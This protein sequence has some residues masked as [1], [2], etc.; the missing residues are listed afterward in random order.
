[1]DSSCARIAL[2]SAAE[3]TWVCCGLVYTQNLPLKRSV[4]MLVA[5]ALALMLPATSVG[6]RGDACPSNSTIEPAATR[7]GCIAKIVN[8]IETPKDCEALCCAAASEY[9]SKSEPNQGCNAWFINDYQQCFMCS[10]ARDPVVPPAVPASK[11]GG[12]KSATP[13][14][15]NC[16]TG[17]VQG[18]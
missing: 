10:G 1:M 15:T 5:A 11:Q 13:S 9:S 7:R 17:L 3:L 14:E 16:T 6:A 18:R 8:K 2:A 12:C 4:M